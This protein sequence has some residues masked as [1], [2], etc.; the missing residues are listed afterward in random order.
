M[1]E[2]YLDLHLAIRLINICYHYSYSKYSCSNKICFNC[3]VAISS[4]YLTTQSLLGSH[5]Y[6]HPLNTMQERLHLEQY[7]T[8]LVLAQVNII[9][10]YSVFSYPLYYFRF[11]HNN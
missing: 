8:N 6:Q 9:T 1:H 7:K 2:K 10:K 5:M 11:V 3:L 4:T